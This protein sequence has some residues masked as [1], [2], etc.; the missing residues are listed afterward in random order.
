VTE[1]FNGTFVT[2]AGNSPGTPCAALSAGITGQFYGDEVFTVPTHADFNF[3]ATCPVGCRATQFFDAFFNTTPPS[4][5]WQFHYTTPGNG[6]WDNTDH[7][8]SG[9]ITD[10]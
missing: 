9:N 8:D 2:L 7:G 1:L 5:A 10:P 4:Y 3:T 6:S